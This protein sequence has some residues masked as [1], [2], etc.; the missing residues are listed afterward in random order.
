MKPSIVS[1]LFVSL[2]I[3]AVSYGSWHLYDFYTSSRPQMILSEGAGLSLLSSESKKN[4]AS[5]V[6]SYRPNEHNLALFCQKLRDVFPVVK[7][8]TLEQKGPHKVAVLVECQRP[9]FVFNNQIVLTECDT[10]LSAGWYASEFLAKLPHFAVADA[11][12]SVCGECVD[13]VKHLPTP[14]TSLYDIEWVD[15]SLVRFRDKQ[16][17]QIMVLGSAETPGERLLH[18]SCDVLKMALL[19]R[20]PSRKGQKNDWCIDLR[21]KGQMVVFPGGKGTYEKVVYG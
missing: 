5:F 15:S 1:K 13:Y 19:E 7:A 14:L 20:K 16:Y 2:T 18:Y 10:Q 12:P 9:Q 6:R 11:S 3:V 8:V 17:P 4:L 21:F